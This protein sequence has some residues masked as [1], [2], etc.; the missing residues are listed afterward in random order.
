MCIAAQIGWQ[1]REDEEMLLL[2]SGASGAGKTSVRETIAGQLAP[3]VEAVEERDLDK[4]GRHLLVAG[5]PAHV[6]PSSRPADG[7]ACN[8]RN[9]PRCRGRSPS[10]TAQR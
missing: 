8:G 9:W 4:Q 2:I 6:P 3:G 7:T 5:D 10:S 1:G